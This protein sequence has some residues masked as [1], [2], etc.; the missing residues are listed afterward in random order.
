MSWRVE[1]D[2]GRCVGSGMCV[3]VA[4]DHF[5]LHGE[6]SRPR[7]AEIAAA[8][9]VMAAATCCPMEAITITDLVTGQLR[10]GTRDG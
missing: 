3:G 1:V 4:P 6:A 10:Y 2:P 8:E 7:T 9:A 5:T